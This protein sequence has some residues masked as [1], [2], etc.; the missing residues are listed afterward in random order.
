[1]SRAAL[2]LIARLRA[3]PAAST[4]LLGLLVL[5]KFAF[6]TA[7]LAD[8]LRSVTVATTTVAAMAAFDDNA[9]DACWHAGKAGCHCACAHGAAMP[10]LDE[11]QVAQPVA[12]TLVPDDVSPLRLTRLQTDLRP[13]IA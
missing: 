3:R 4:W 6:G 11:V 10:V 12:I 2:P 7:C 8:E 5:V 13:P 9:S 1:M